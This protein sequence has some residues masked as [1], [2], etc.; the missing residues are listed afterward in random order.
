MAKKSFSGG[1]DSLLGG[2]PLSNS[3]PKKEEK[4]E[5]P[6]VEPTPSKPLNASTTSEVSTSLFDALSEE[7]KNKIKALADKEGR[8]QEEILK[9]AVAFYL[10]FQVDL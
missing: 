5:A 6:I 10:D 2:S 4:K 1:L 8:K 3:T 7:Q 9:E